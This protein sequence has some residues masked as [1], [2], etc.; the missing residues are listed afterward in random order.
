MSMIRKLLAKIM[1]KIEPENKPQC[2]FAIVY[3]FSEHD[4][5]DGQS[6][7]F[8]C[9]EQGDRWE[10]GWR[11][12]YKIRVEGGPSYDPSELTYWTPLPKIPKDMRGEE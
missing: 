8:V 4:P 7:A 5:H 10:V 1:A 3:K 12:W 6:F 11:D 2:E 9:P